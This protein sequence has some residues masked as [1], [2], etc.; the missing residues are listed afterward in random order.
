[1][2][3]PSFFRRSKEGLVKSFGD[4]RIERHFLGDEKV[5]RITV[6][7]DSDYDFTVSIGEKDL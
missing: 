6:F 3:V 1:M 5:N 7:G 2:I 4:G